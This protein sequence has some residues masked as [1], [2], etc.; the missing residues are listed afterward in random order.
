MDDQGLCVCLF[1]CQLGRTVY[2]LI[3]WV[4]FCVVGWLWWVAAELRI[5]V[6]NIQFSTYVI[7]LSN[8]EKSQII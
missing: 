7:V 8:N 2:G 5:L 6:L 4:G 1:V 3:Y